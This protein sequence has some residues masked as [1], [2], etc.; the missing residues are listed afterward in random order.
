MAVGQSPTQNVRLMAVGQS[1]VVGQ[2]RHL[3]PHCRG[4]LSDK[5]IAAQAALSAPPTAFCMLVRNAAKYL[6]RNVEFILSYL[7]VACV[8]WRLFYLENDSVDGTQ[9]ILDA[10]SKRDHRVQGKRLQT[11]DLHTGDSKRLCPKDRNCA[12]RTNF[13]GYLRTLLVK[14]VLAWPAAELLVMMDIDFICVDPTHF[15]RMFTHVLLPYN[16]SGVFGMSVNALK[17]T[18]YDVGAI[19]PMS[20]V[21]AIQRMV[22]RREDRVVPVLSAFSGFGL[23]SVRAI[24]SAHATYSYPNLT[25]ALNRTG[26]D[27]SRRAALYGMIEH[28]PFNLHLPRLYV[29]TSFSPEYCLRSDV[30]D[31]GRWAPVQSGAMPRSLLC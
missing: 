5:N 30:W 20:T 19:V 21:V 4:N 22:A 13:L 18:P 12:L 31:S 17:H 23:Y 11:G 28:I 1:A 10:F 27:L 24:R 16:A 7:T 9:A 25:E 26:D 2:H 29:L 3:V 8:D 6:E 15:W 14:Q